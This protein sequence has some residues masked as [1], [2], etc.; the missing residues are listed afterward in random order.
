MTTTDP[1]EIP[2]SREEKKAKMADYYNVAP[3]L[4]QGEAVA[5]K[6]TIIIAFANAGLKMH[7]NAR[8]GMTRNNRVH[9]TPHLITEREEEFA[10]LRCG[11]P[12]IVATNAT[13]EAAWQATYKQSKRSPY[14]GMDEAYTVESM[15]RQQA[16]LAEMQEK[17]DN[18]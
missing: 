2:L 17:G 5:S 7:A 4:A 3:V 15:M 13:I 1:G 18:A 10:C 14:G 6:P 8:C 12:S 9:N 16:Q 11:G